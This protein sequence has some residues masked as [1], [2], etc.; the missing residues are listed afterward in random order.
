M[1]VAIATC[2]TPPEPDP[3]EALLLGA[4]RGAG[5]DASV[6]AWDDERAQAAFAEQ[7][8]VVLRST[9]NYHQHVDAFVAW[10]ARMGA[11]TRVLNPPRIVAWN[12]KKTY[13]AELEGR[14]VAI[15][16]TEFV[17]R[18]QERDIISV[19]AERGWEQVVIKPV[20]SAGSFRTERFSREELPAAQVFLDGLVA[21]RDAMV[22][23]WMPSVQ[24]YGERSLVWI[25]GEIT[26][27][28][29]K[30]PRFAGGVEQVSGEVPI[31][32]DERAFA[33]RALAP[34]A[35]ELLYAR[36]D[37]VRDAEDVLRIMEL[38]LIEPSLFF[39][40]SKGALGRFVAAIVR[41]LQ[42]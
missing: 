26:H 3:D 38:E 23:Q 12:A 9:W 22:Q 27:A 21:D 35:A 7:D 5:L 18:G 32:A 29:R 36:V 4:L 14:G 1:R 2:Q 30:T 13:L 25:D 19:F 15:V 41:R 10:T 31:A 40:Q 17:V 42:R 37:M 20:V 28:I 34:I 8:L 24:T 33:E 16:P 39:E 11:S 6:L